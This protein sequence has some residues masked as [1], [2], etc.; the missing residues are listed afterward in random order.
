[1]FSF[2]HVSVSMN[3]YSATNQIARRLYALTRKA[4]PKQEAANFLNWKQL[5]VQ[6]S[7]EYWSV[8]YLQFS[9]P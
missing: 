8:L 7:N 4:N 2:Q 9:Y 6:G 3:A 5:T 1:M